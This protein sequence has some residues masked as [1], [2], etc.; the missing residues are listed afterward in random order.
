MSDESI[1]DGRRTKLVWQITLSTVLLAALALNVAALSIR[2]DLSANMVAAVSAYIFL[3]IYYRIVRP[4]PEVGRALISFG[5]LVTVVT[6]GILL[7]YAASTV[8]LPYRDA[9][10]YA[11]DRWLGFER[12]TYIEFLRRHDSLRGVFSFAY[13]T[14]MHQNILVLLIAIM[15]R[16]GDRLQTYIIA[17]AIAVTATAAIASVVPAMNAMIYV[18][19]V[20]RDLATLPDGG[21]SYFPILEGLRNGTVRA[22]DFSGRIAGLISFPSFHTANAVLFVWTLWPIRILR[23]VLLPLNLLLIA[24]TPLCG[25]HYVTDIVGG[26][27]VAVGAIIA[28][29]WLIYMPRASECI[30]GFAAVVPETGR[31]I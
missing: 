12:D 16:R 20:S 27:A 26:V 5:Q 9:Q 21:H 17:F 8:P 1:V 23:A 30:G 10:L 24:S 4:N 31:A 7:S 28:T 15:A 14:M 13:N 29:T 6:M 3:L 11:L 2:L 19:G 25:A 22:V 18:D